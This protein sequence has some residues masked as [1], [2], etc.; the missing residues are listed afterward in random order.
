[1]RG[2]AELGHLGKRI[3]A[4]F[5]V[6]R[7]HVARVQVLGPGVGQLVQ[8]PAW[9]HGVLLL[10]PAVGE[11]L[12]IG[13]AIAWALTSVAM[14][15]IAGR[16]LWRSSV[17]RTLL[18]ALAIGVYAVPTGLLGSIQQAEP[19]ALAFLLGSTLSS[20]VIGDSLYFVAAARIGVA[21]ALPIAS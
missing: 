21:R 14:R 8:V 13:S 18:C 3:D 20:I 17:L 15:P 6:V 11:L 19:R 2:Q 4:G 9:R 10:C 5:A 16:A 12:A 1:I 7:G